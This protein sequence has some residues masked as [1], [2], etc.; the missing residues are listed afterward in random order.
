M[1]GRH[2]TL[3][4]CLLASSSLL[5]CA[6]PGPDGAFDAPAVDSPPVTLEAARPP[7]P[8][9]VPTPPGFVSL[10]ATSSGAVFVTT[11]AS[12]PEP[13]DPKSPA[14][15]PLVHIERF[16]GV[17]CELSPDGTAPVAAAWLMDV[18]DLGNLFV[19]PAE[20]REP[21]FTS[22][23]L[24]DKPFGDT[25]A[26]VDTAGRVSEVLT[27]GRGL[28][29]FGVSPAG[30]SLWVTACGPTGIF[31][32]SSDEPSQFTVAL[33]S[34]ETLWEQ[35]PSVLTDDHTFWSVGVRTSVSNEPIT[36]AS[37]YALVR[38]T[39]EGSRDLGTT[40]VDFGKG[41]EKATLTRCGSRVCGLF[42]GAVIV[43]GSEGEVL[44]TLTASDLGALPSEHIARVS[45]NEHGLYFS[46]S[47]TDGRRVLF[48]PTR[49]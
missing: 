48:V 44:D 14:P 10:L 42:S 45:G 19:S 47:G 28:W 25:V 38:T 43:W 31:A 32:F 6:S 18:D 35:M 4:A 20:T 29:D 37:G 15:E 40:L 49:Q 41:F 30:G 13:S 12:R 27:A 3:L 1:H 9:V 21:G 24:P 26:R 39:P 23:V 46:L 16:S 5:A 8:C 17:G 33:E 22:T 7:S 2:P 34:P 36:P 11:S